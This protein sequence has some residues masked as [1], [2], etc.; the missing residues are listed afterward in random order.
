MY[1]L[2]FALLADGVKVEDVYK[3]LATPEGVDRAFAKLSEL[4]PNIQWWEAGAQPAQW[5]I[6]GRFTTERR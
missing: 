6:A 1:N 2:E 3:V 4:K 5:L